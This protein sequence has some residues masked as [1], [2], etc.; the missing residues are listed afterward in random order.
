MYSQG[1]SYKMKL[2]DISDPYETQF[3]AR[4]LNDT[5]QARERR[6]FGSILVQ[7]IPGLITLAME[8]VSSYIKGRQQQKINTAVEELRND[9]NKI[10]ND[11]DNIEM[12]C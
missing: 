12:N 11:L 5:V 10:R 4:T 9:D 3:M 7:A 6:G 1:P 8:G 2:N